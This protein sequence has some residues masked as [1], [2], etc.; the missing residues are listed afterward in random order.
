[1]A[2]V[3]MQ[4]VG[5]IRKGGTF[6]IGE[7]ETPEACADEVVIA[8]ASCGICGTDLAFLRED[9]APDGAVLGHEFSGTV[10]SAGEAVR[11][12]EAGQRVTVNPMVNHVGLG[13]IPGA[14]AQYVRLPSPEPGRNIFRLPDTIDDDAGAL[15][16]P[17][18]VGLHAVN[19]SG[20]RPGERVVI[21]GAGPIGLCVLAA[22]RARGM[23]NVLAIDPSAKRRALAQAM[24][25]SAVHD[26]AEGSSNAFVA[27]HFGSLSFP[28]SVDPIAQADIA[29]DCAGVRPALH[30][31]LHSLKSGGRLVLVADPHDVELP[32]L[33]LVMLH[34]LQVMG[35]LAYSNEFPEAIDLLGR[36]IV[37]LSLLVSHR[38]ALAE[39]AT[40]FRTQLDAEE[41]I[42]VLVRAGP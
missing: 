12:I 39:L 2:K 9:S 36:G 27:A 22:L 41:A 37:D 23:E 3:A 11:G 14:F 15:I 1:M 20:A 32:D 5:R 25:A 35:A 19:R 10:V 26:P 24:G 30:D 29:F 17:F 18:A 8:V 28:Y 6:E 16:E 7:A 21:F 31:A 34:E 13:R 4:Q 38:F 33:R 42:K 40:A